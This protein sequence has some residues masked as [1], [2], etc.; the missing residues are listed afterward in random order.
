MVDSGVVVDD[1][2]VESEL[3][4]LHR[5]YEVCHSPTSAHVI[6][7]IHIYYMY[8]RMHIMVL[9]RNTL[10]LQCVTC[11]TVHLIKSCDLFKCL[12]IYICTYV[13]CVILLK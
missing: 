11:A 7:S 1:F 6:Y 12:Y 10:I 2:T 9:Q 13:C 8:I 4:G 5:Y 3:S